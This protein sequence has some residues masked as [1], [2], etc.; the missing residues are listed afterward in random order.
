VVG[1]L[2]N[3]AQGGK[4]QDGFLSAA[5]SSGAGHLGIKPTG[6]VGGTITSGIIGGT[7]STLGGGKFANGAYTAAFQYL[8]ND[9]LVGVEKT[10]REKIIEQATIGA[11][12][13]NIAKQFAYSEGPTLGY[14]KN[15]WK[16][17][18]FT[19]WVTRALGIEAVKISSGEV[20]NYEAGTHLGDPNEKIT[21]Y[22]KGQRKIN[23]EFI[24]TNDPQPGDIVSYRNR[25]YTESSGHTGFISSISKDSK[26]IYTISA[27]QA[28]ANGLFTGSFAASPGS[29]DYVFRTFKPK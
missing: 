5:A 26:G 14:S 29:D 28:G 6:R 8:T 19:R 17:S 23:G 12:D 9:A 3:A 16:C 2:S 13:P 11:N 27:I 1:G 15:S 4:F 21:T 18:C 22:A 7:A 20:A 24:V 10:W 25:G